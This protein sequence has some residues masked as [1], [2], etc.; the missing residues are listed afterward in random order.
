MFPRNASGI[1]LHRDAIISKNVCIKYHVL[2]EE[3]NGSGAPVID[4]NFVINPYSKIIGN[5]HI[6]KNCVIG[7]GSIVTKDIPDNLFI[8]I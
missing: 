1:I 4:E 2:L 5:V 7:A 8:T 6:E 3:K